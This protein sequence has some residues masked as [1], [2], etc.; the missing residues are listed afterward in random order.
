MRGEIE[1]DSP[2]RRSA[3]IENVLYSVAEHSTIAVDIGDVTRQLAE[4]RYDPADDSESGE[5]SDRLLGDDAMVAEMVQ[6]AKTSLS[7]ERGILEGQILSITAES[8]RSRDGSMQTDADDFDPAA[9]AGLRIVL[10]V[11]DEKYLFHTDRDDT[12]VLVEE[13]F[14]FEPP[15]V[16]W[17]NVAQPHDVDGD[18][19]VTPRDALL[20][21]NELN[22]QGAYRLSPDH[23][24]RVVHFQR[25]YALD[26]DNDGFLA[27][28]DAL[29]VINQLNAKA[30]EAAAAEGEMA[31][32]SVLAAETTMTNT[33]GSW[34]A[35]ASANP[36]RDHAIHS[37]ST[38][39]PSPLSEGEVGVIARD[40]AARSA[41]RKHACLRRLVRIVLLAERLNTLRFQPRLLARP[42]LLL[43]INV[44]RRQIS[45][46]ICIVSEQLQRSRFA[47]AQFLLSETCAASYVALI[48][49]RRDVRQRPND[50]E[51]QHGN[52]LAVNRSGH[53]GAQAS[54]LIVQ[55]IQNL[56]SIE[57]LDWQVRCDRD[58]QP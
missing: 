7:A 5:G 25:N 43:L 51:H 6:K 3:F 33:Q 54:R 48:V 27:P 16:E 19:I 40:V 49:Y 57:L 39:A 29:Y 55:R 50:I 46:E 52:S 23:V 34:P 45:L 8:A 21:I 47:W 38:L 17:H 58:Q 10:G 42:V 28:R 1:H 12:V 9:V 30:S 24:S 53:F 35:H 37:V 56:P 13:T 22:R 11:A 26:V 15:H 2:V 32:R 36:V 20:L 14:E 41:V 31:E 4:V 18:T 44:A